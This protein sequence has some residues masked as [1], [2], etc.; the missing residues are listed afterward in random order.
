MIVAFLTLNRLRILSIMAAML[1]ASLS[2]LVG[3]IDG[4]ERQRDHLVRERSMLIL[5]TRIT[6]NQ[7]LYDS[8]LLTTAK[9]VEIENL[10]ERISGLSDLKTALFSGLVGLNFLILILLPAPSSETSL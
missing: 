6:G 10:S 8:E 1:A 7:D 5:E 9:T 4:F 2:V 3:R